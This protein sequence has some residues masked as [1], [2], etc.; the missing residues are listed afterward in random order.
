MPSFS[1]R[2]KKMEHIINEVSSEYK[3]ASYWLPYDALDIAD[4]F[5][6][7]ELMLFREFIDEIDACID[8][9]EREAMLVHNIQRYGGVVLKGL[10][11]AQIV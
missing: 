9:N 3:E 4:V 1:S 7:D 8:E 5:T 2:R 10:R 11:L 6:E